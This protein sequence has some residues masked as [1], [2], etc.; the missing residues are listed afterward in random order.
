MEYRLQASSFPG[1]FPTP[2]PS[3]EERGAEKAWERG[4]P[5][6]IR[7]KLEKHLVYL[8]PRV[9]LFIQCDFW[10]DPGDFER[11]FAFSMSACNNISSGWGNVGLFIAFFAP[12]VW[13]FC[14]F[15]LQVP[16][17]M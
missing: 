12:W 3:E 9:S 4:G 5:H 16:L 8:A 10:L 14:M 11:F 17:K 15:L 2:P 6:P 1:P 13:G 7:W